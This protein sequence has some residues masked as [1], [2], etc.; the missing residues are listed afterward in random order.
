MRSFPAPLTQEELDA[1]IKMDEMRRQGRSTQTKTTGRKRST[2]SKQKKSNAKDPLMDLKDAFDG[3]A[4]S[5]GTS[6]KKRRTKAGP[7][8]RY[9]VVVCPGCDAKNRVP[10]E[11]LKKKLPVC[12]R[13]KVDLSFERR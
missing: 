3:K 1:Q 5:S 7:A 10:L 9:L 8:K 11:R 2:T 4:A 13:C 12:G 6:T